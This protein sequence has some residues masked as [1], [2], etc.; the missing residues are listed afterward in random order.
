IIGRLAAR[1]FPTVAESGRAILRQQAAIGGNA[2]H[3]GDAEAYRELMLQR[4][5][6]DFERMSGETDVP[7]FFD[8]GIA[9]LAGYSR[10][11]GVAVPAHVRRAAALYRY[12]PTVFVAPPW[13]EIYVN[14]DLR[15]QDAA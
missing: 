15:R 5:V 9:E 12:N 3:H 8:R 10:L 7:V 4:G 11:I 14:D 6:D 2:V 13:P 1:G